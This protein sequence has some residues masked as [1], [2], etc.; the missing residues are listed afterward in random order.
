[1]HLIFCL[2]S[3]DFAVVGQSIPSLLT[4]HNFGDKMHIFMKWWCTND[5]TMYVILELVEQA[6]EVV[7]SFTFTLYGIQVDLYISG[8][9]SNE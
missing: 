1:M 7:N 6:M 9:N 8:S 3:A 5:P 2:S 4:R